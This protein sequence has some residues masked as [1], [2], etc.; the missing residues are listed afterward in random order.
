MEPRTPLTLLLLT[1]AV[2]ALGPFVDQVG[3]RSMSAPHDGISRPILA[4]EL[5]QSP[6]DFD[7]IVHEKATPPKGYAST[8]FWHATAA[9]YVLIL[10]YGFM[11]YSLL[12]HVSRVDERRVVRR[13][14]AA[15]LIVGVVADCVENAG[16]IIGLRGAL[17]TAPADLIRWASLIKWACLGLALLAIAWRFVPDRARPTGPGTTMARIAWGIECALVALY[18]ATGAISLVGVL[19]HGVLEWFGLPLALAL[20]LQL[21]WTFWIG[22]RV[23]AAGSGYE[24]K[25]ERVRARELDYVARRRQQSD[26]TFPT[27]TQVSDSLV[28]LALSGGGIRSATTNLGVLQALS[29]MKLLQ[30]VDYL[31]TVSGGG[32]IGACLSS[33]LSIRTKDA[34]AG[35]TQ[36]VA[37]PAETFQFST[38]WERFPFNADREPGTPRRDPAAERAGKKIVSH[39]RTH[40]SFLIARRGFLERDALRAVGHLLTGTTYHLVTTLLVFFVSTLVLMGLAHT[41]EPDLDAQLKA[42]VK[43]TTREIAS[44]NATAGGGYKVT[45]VE[46]PTLGDQ[47]AG[48]FDL[49]WTHLTEDTSVKPL[50]QG[51]VWGIGASLLVFVGFIV[52]THRFRERPRSWGPGESQEDRFDR[53]LIRAACIVVALTVFFACSLLPAVRENARVGC[54][55]GPF[56]VL[57][58]VCLTNFLLYPLIARVDAAGG[59]DLWSRKFRSLWGSFQA[60]SAYGL[61]AALLFA[62]LPIVAYAVRASFDERESLWSLL[63]PI[64]SLIAGRLLVDGQGASNARRLRLPTGVRHFLL[65]VLVCV[66]VGFVVIG[67]AA[68]GVRYEFSKPDSLELNFW[69]ALFASGLALVFLSVVGNINRISP[70]YFYRDRL[71]ETYLRTE[72]R[73]ETNQ[74]E[75][76]TDTME[77]PL[78]GLHGEEPDGKPVGNSAPYLL[79]STA[80]NLSGS[81]DLTR[82]DRKSAHFLFSKYFCG[83]EHTGYRDTAAYR[84][85][86]TKLGGAMTISGAAASSA[87][88]YHTFF[89][90]SFLTSILNLRLGVWLVNPRMTDRDEKGVFWPRYMLREVFGGTNE[91]RPLVNLSDGGHTGD[92]IGIYPLLERRCQVIIACDAEADPT[93]SFGSFTEA[94]RQAYVDLDIDVDIDL[95]MIRPDPETGLSKSH[96]AV[97]RIRYPEHPERAN[98]LIYLKSS[99]TG[100][101]PAPV[102]N[103]RSTSPAFP[104]ET[105]ADQFFDD[106]QFESY[107]SLGVH[108]AQHTF[109]AWGAAGR[110]EGSPRSAYDTSSLGC[111]AWQDLVYRHTPF[112]PVEDEDFQRLLE[113]S[114]ELER[115]FLDTP[116]LEGYYRECMGLLPAG[117]PTPRRASRHVAVMQLQLMEDVY[118]SLRL[119][120]YANAPDN[121]GWMNTFRRWGNSPTF[122]SHVA[123]IDKTFSKAFIDFFHFYVRRWRAD[124]PVPHPWDLDVPLDLVRYMGPTKH[125][126]E[127]CDDTKG[128]GV[129]LDPG[130]REAGRR[131]QKDQHG[132]SRLVGEEAAPEARPPA[133]ASTADAPA[134]P[135]YDDPN[136]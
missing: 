113:R 121:R 94:L 55:T 78:T 60:F 17:G 133:A 83:S 108:I 62:C 40:G 92:N 10:A 68:L 84:G 16:I 132:K 6:A 125:A 80:I 9:D 74:M 18:V 23:V 79:I 56:I 69:V 72:A 122:I 30:H 64:V 39:L 35:N 130:R 20:P 87:M 95:S 136:R 32:Y 106:A 107:R 134:T 112:R 105:T 36:R 26:G 119:D 38:D 43:E 22:N 124:D 126:L 81:R 70:H 46:E 66:F 4:I 59:L 41:I 21:A 103:Y 25:F 135:P 28:G 54:V 77:M 29:Q 24:D 58:G 82:K 102:L 27:A 31:C 5:V 115:L 118:Y 101:E 71:L 131:P 96:C 120:H 44:V 123:E 127:R 57:V 63:A 93:L 86:S 116:A 100:D 47:L 110:G 50:M 33:L 61:A 65:G 7:V 85:G 49:A 109:A 8:R 89:A 1:L 128:P 2:M 51:V 19:W 42:K 34:A 76:F 67:F 97:G 90:L 98:W 13:A 91:R 11:W 53:L 52:A 129:F 73:G 48:R 111:D 3:P 14:G 88:G 117:P 37:T 45:E 114:G 104:H 99:L 75:T 12:I 15:A